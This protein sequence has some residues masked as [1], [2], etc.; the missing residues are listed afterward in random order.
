MHFVSASPLPSFM[1]PATASD[2]VEVRLLACQGR[3]SRVVG[4]RL[5]CRNAVSARCSLRDVSGGTVYREGGYGRVAGDSGL[6]S[7][8][9]A[10]VLVA[11]SGVQFPFYGVGGMAVLEF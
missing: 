7:T 5:L 1:R 10:Q 2:L 4:A 6:L 8:A 11:H 3:P 9:V